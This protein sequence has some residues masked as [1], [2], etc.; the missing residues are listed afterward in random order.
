M[1]DGKEIGKWYTYLRDHGKDSDPNGT[2]TVRD[3]ILRISGQDFGG[4]VTRDEYANYEVRLEYAWGGTVW[5]PRDKSARDSGLLVHST[6]PDG[7]VA[8]SWMEG[9]QCNMIEGG[10]GDISITGTNR[11][12]G[13]RAQA[14][15]RP[16]GKKTGLY[17]KDGAPART[18]GPGSRLLWFGR[19]PAWQNVLGFRGKNDVEKGVKE[20]NTLLVTMKGD[21]MTVRLNGVILSRATNLG[22]TRGRL[23]IQTEGSELLIRK[24]TL[25]PLD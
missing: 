2:F 18:F 6:G 10:T 21:T 12:Y 19:D 15:E 5:P 11:K 3:G 8:K 17:W 7:A 25:T 24:I 9:L 1:F 16:M 13:F 4:L 14:E 23:Q 22:I 20:W